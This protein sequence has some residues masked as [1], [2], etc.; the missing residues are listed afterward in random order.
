MDTSDATSVR[1]RVWEIIFEA[2][3]PA[4]KA[5]DV[6][7]LA[8]ILLSVGAVMLESVDGIRESFGP[9]LVAAEWVFTILFTIEYILRLCVV[10]RPLRYAFSFFGIVDLLSVL[11]TYLLLFGVGAQSLLVIRSLRLLRTFRVF[12]LARY[13]G[14]ASILRQ[15]L[16]ASRPKITVFLLTVMTIVLIVG[17]LMHLIEGSQG[18]EGFSNLPESVYWAIVTMTTVG[19]GDA[20]PESPMGKAIASFVMIMG[21]GIIAVPTGIVTAELSRVRPFVTTRVCPSCHAE[22]HAPDADFCMRCGAEL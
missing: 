11:P 4:G 6:A 5:F 10:R 8:A 21:Y 15:A 1:Q 19:Y 3:T 14:E 18:N 9:Q 13:V 22:G 2:D 7:L 20:T 17:A 12:K 16:A